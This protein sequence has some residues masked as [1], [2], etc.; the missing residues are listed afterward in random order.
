MIPLANTGQPSTM[1]PCAMALCS[2]LA[3]SARPTIGSRAPAATALS[4]AR[5][6]ASV[7]PLVKVTEPSLA[8]TNRATSPRD[9]STAARAVRPAAWTEDGLPPIARAQATAS[10]ASGR[11]GAVAL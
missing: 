1:W 6:L 7:P 4:M 10:A 2:V 9:R 5:A 8:P 3:C 11:I